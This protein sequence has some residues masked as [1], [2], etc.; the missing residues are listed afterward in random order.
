MLQTRRAR[1]A[2]IES[3]F[4]IMPDYLLPRANLQPSCLASGS[5]Y[6]CDYGSRFLGCCTSDPCDNGCPADKLRPITYNTG[7]TNSSPGLCSAGSFWY[8]C[9]RTDPPFIG[10]CRRVACRLGGCPDG[11]LTA[12]TLPTDSQAKEP[13]SPSGKP[14]KGKNTGAI[15]GG[16]VGGVAGI[17]L[18]VL[19]LAWWRWRR[20]KISRA[21]HK[22]TS[23]KAFLSRV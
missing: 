4:L 13:W 17:T 10:C 19:L 21:D 2:I 9:P 20:A 23:P 6:A 14:S 8:K 18:I 12:A 15:A 3:T 16:V 1:G 22:A 7:F 5:F 11:N